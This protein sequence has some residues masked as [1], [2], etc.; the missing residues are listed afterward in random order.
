MFE[1]FNLCSNRMIKILSALCRQG[2]EE[3]FPINAENSLAKATNFTD[4]TM[5]CLT[6]VPQQEYSYASV[7]FILAMYNLV[8]NFVEKAFPK[9]VLTAVKI[10]FPNI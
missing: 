10:M 5:S 6:A 1:N 9:H 7:P 8:I 3:T 2:R 4:H